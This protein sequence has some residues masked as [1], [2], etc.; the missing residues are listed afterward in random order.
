MSLYIWPNFC[1][2]LNR[3]KDSY[4]ALRHTQRKKRSEIKTGEN[5]APNVGPIRRSHSRNIRDTRSRSRST[6]QAPYY[7]SKSVC[8]TVD[9]DGYFRPVVNE[10]EVINSTYTGDKNIE[11]SRS[12]SSSSVGFA[13]KKVTTV[14]FSRQESY[15]REMTELSKRFVE[16]KDVYTERNRDTVANQFYK[17]LA[18]VKREEYKRASQ[19][20]TK[21]SKQK[22]KTLLNQIEDLKRLNSKYRRATEQRYNAKFSTYHPTNAAARAEISTSAQKKSKN[23]HDFSKWRYKHFNMNSSGKIDK[24]RKQRQHGQKGYRGPQ[25]ERQA[26]NMQQ[27][28]SHEQNEGNFVIGKLISNLGLPRHIY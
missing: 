8:S 14:P 23:S 11:R 20:S 21:Q 15:H 3:H 4:P 28:L 25:W 16:T 12:R 22:Q 24:D 26:T 13:R 5:K 1:F 17:N 7:R 19:S 27:V 6:N 10:Q 2:V 18:D 9:D